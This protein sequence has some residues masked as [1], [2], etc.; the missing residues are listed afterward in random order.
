MEDSIQAAGNEAVS[1]QVFLSPPRIIQEERTFAP[2]SSTLFLGHKDAILVDAQFYK[3]DVEALIDTI[4]ASG[5]RL[6]T[7]YLTHGHFDHWYGAGAIAAR[8]PGTRILAL[9]GVMAYIG[10][11]K[12]QEAQIINAM[13]GDRIVNPLALP[14]T[15]EGDTIDLEGHT[16]QAIEIGQGDVP[17]NTVLHSA[18][19]KTAIVGDLA[20]NNIHMMLGLSGPDEWDQWASNIGKIQKLAPQIV[21]VG[22]K[23]EGSADN[24]PDRILTESRKYIG[25][26]KTVALREKNAPAIVAEMTRLYPHFGNVT[27]LEFSALS[28][29]NVLNGQTPPSTM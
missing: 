1:M 18:E 15:M 2:V 6:T 26:F 23:S 7:I 9:P 17:S 4:A 19:L 24:E 25:D 27:T 8:F 11:A 14:E 13:F 12:E 5:K 3:E 22:H 29:A 10:A 20:Y 28:V 16:F 21:V